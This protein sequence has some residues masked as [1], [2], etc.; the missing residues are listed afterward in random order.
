MHVCTFIKPQQ[1]CVDVIRVASSYSSS[2]SSKA[3]H[4]TQQPCLSATGISTAARQPQPSSTTHDSSQHRRR[5]AAYQP[6]STVRAVGKV[7]AAE[8]AVSAAAAALLSSKAVSALRSQKKPC[9]SSTTKAPPQ[10]QLKP[11]PSPLASNTHAEATTACLQVEGIHT[12]PPARSDSSMP[13]ALQAACVEAVA[14]AGPPSRFMQAIPST[15]AGSASSSATVLPPAAAQLAAYGLSKR[16]RAQLRSAYGP[17]P[18]QSC[19][20]LPPRPPSPPP[21][22]LDGELSAMGCPTATYVP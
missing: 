10:R 11:A 20:A 14:A 6:L 8:A 15:S 22:V 17:P 21:V 5:P 12:G 18:F 19:T 4:P 1:T 16:I 3:A 9:A 13:G 2:S 7:A